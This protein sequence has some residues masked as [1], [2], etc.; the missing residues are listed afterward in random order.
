MEKKPESCGSL[1][2]EAFV[3]VTLQNKSLKMPCLGW[4]FR[5]VIFDLAVLLLPALPPREKCTKKS[6]KY[7]QNSKKGVSKI[8]FKK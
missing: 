1:K 8:K 7:F 3:S 2:N 6:K 5:A 4:F